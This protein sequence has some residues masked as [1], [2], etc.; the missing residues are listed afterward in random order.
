VKAPDG[1]VLVDADYAGMELRLAAQIANDPAMIAAF[2]SGEDLHTVTAEAIGSTRQIA[3]SANFGL[4]FGSGATGLRNY[5]GASGITMSEDEAKAIR[6]AWL[7]KFSGINAWQRANAEAADAAPPRDR[8]PE[9]RIPQSGMRRFLPGD[10]N[11]L[12]V[13]CNTP[14]Q[15]AG[16]SILKLALGNLWREVKKAGEQEVRIAAA[17]HDQI[18]LLVKEEH[19]EKWCS[20]LKDVMEAAESVWLG[21]VPAMAEAKIGK[22]WAE[23]H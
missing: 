2:Q 7:A 11:R 14:V 20:T 3:K 1:W 12:T 19:A 9:I 23:S 5:A 10:L 18:V 16:A 17:I 4:L 15:G 13:R 8:M 6:S 21:D 22:T